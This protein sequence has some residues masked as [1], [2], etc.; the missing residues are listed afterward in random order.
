MA[1]SGLPFDLL[2]SRLSALEQA[3]NSHERVHVHGG[4]F[5]T[6]LLTEAFSQDIG[7]RVD[8][9]ADR[10]RLGITQSHTVDRNDRFVLHRNS[11]VSTRD[12]TVHEIE[13]VD[14][15]LPWF[16][17]AGPPLWQ[18]I[19]AS[20]DICDPLAGAARVQS[21]SRSGIRYLNTLGMQHENITSRPPREVELG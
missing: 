14:K 13:V 15:T 1:R 17:R 18:G 21:L 5:L 19:R 10:H 8:R 6:L 12:V 7:E 16:C 2:F 9:D 3:L 4:Q 11:A 20:L